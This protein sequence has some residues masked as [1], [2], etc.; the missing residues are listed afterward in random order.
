MK[1]LLLGMS[2]LLSIQMGQAF[3]EQK[4]QIEVEAISAGKTMSLPTASSIQSTLPRSKKQKEK[5][6]LPPVGKTLFSSSNIDMFADGTTDKTTSLSLTVLNSKNGV[7]RIKIGVFEEG[8]V[9][10][11][12]YIT[13]RSGNQYYGN[14]SVF[15]G[16]S[17]ILITRVKDH[18]EVVQTFLDD[19]TNEVSVSRSIFPLHQDSS[20]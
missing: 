14:S 4:D 10:T 1:R 20:K 7:A 17:D 16:S 2:L 19:T 12:I 5:D 13:G 8:A 11:N 3:A 18:L 15:I 6:I 9:L